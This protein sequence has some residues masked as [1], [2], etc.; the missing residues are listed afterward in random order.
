LA[1]RAICWTVTETSL[2]IIQAQVRDG[3]IAVV[4]ALN[5]GQKMNQKGR[6]TNDLEA[7]A[8]L[9]FRTAVSD[10]EQN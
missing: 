9:Q 7:H 1:A 4:G 5:Q 8:I 10:Q 6:G 2:G 3:F